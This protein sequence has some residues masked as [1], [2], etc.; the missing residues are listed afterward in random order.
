MSNALLKMIPLFLLCCSPLS[1][2]GNATSIPQ[3]QQLIQLQQT[4]R[5]FTSLSFKFVQLTKTELRSRSGK[6]NGVFLRLKNPDKTGIMRWNYTEPDPQIFLNDGKKL[7]I[8]TQKDHQL[9]VTSAAELNNEITYAFF[10][11][12]NDLTNEFAIELPDNRYVFTLA[13]TSLHMLRLT[14][15]KPHPQIKAVQIWFDDNFLI[16]HLILE[17]HF[18]STTQLTFTNI[19]TNSIDVE[20]PDRVQAILKLDIPTDTEIIHR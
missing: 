20:D 9:I 19:Q 7:S 12:K 2:S 5:K 10:S 6:G 3:E 17:D 14:P 16:H 18:D 15:N 11:G 4:Y 13:G 8:Y 1:G